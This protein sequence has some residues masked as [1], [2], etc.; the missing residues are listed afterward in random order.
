MKIRCRWYQQVAFIPTFFH[1]YHAAINFIIMRQDLKDIVTDCIEYTSKY[2]YT[3]ISFPVLWSDG[4]GYPP[5]EVVGWI[6]EA[7]ADFSQSQKKTDIKNIYMVV[8]TTN[9]SAEKKVSKITP[10]NRSEHSI[11]I[12]ILR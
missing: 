6:V 9:N 1:Q 10:A 3:S 8:D 4:L 2:R 7:L 12:R 5:D 11:S